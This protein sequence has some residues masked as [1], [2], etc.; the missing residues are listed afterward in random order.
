MILILRSAP[1]YEGHG[2][3]ARSEKKQAYPGFTP[4]TPLGPFQE[5]QHLS[6]T[7]S[8]QLMASIFLLPTITFKSLCF[9]FL[10]QKES[11]TGI[12]KFSLL[13]FIL[14]LQRQHHTVTRTGSR[15]KAGLDSNY[16][17]NLLQVMWPWTNYLTP[18]TLGFLT[19]KTRTSHR[20]RAF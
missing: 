18:P 2:V 19:C 16:T 5:C 4:T 17:A 20:G 7:V 15:K 12:E 14:I 6:G 1:L 13:K 3:V 9:L 8:R 10:N 11:K